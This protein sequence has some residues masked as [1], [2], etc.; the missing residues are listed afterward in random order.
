M[1][2][3]RKV[4]KGVRILLQ[5]QFAGPLIRHRVTAAVEHIEVIKRTSAQTLIDVGANKGQFSLA[6]RKFMP[7]SAIVAF[8]PLSEACA[9][10]KKLFEGDRL[11][12]LHQVAISD[13]RGDAI[14]HVADRS[15]SSSLLKPGNGEAAAF[16][17]HAESTRVVPVRRLDEFVRP[18][19][20]S[21]PILLKIDVQ[22]AELQVLRGFEGLEDVDYV[23]VELSFV[24]LYEGQPLLKDVADYLHGSGFELAGVFNQVSTTRFGPTQ[25][26]FLFRS[27][28]RR[29]RGDA[30]E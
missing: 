28:A 24:E 18:A 9:S 2:A 6:F 22:G 25:A 14:Y 26:D 7:N 29:E 3:W 15:D 20:L 4:K 12:S 13:T 30:K 11:V 5:P 23:Y 10:F 19:V 8:E 16:G 21:R 27:S 1:R 17:V